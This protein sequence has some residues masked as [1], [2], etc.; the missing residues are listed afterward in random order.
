MNEDTHKDQRHWVLLQLG[1]QALMVHPMWVLGTWLQE[2]HLL[3]TVKLS[4]QTSV[5]VFHQ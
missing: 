4:L 1:F 5:N 3:W 2:K